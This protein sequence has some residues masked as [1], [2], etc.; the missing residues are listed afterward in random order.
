VIK[1]KESTGTSY[2]T[3]DRNVNIVEQ[4]K[5][6]VN[7]PRKT[8]HFKSGEFGHE[9]LILNKPETLLFTV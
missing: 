9:L 1:W 4:A 3:Y 5:E 8:G 2:H 6:K 7:L